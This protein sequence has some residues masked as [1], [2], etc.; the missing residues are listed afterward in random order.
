MVLFW[1]VLIAWL[2]KR[3]VHMNK[4]QFFGVFFVFLYFCHTIFTL[5]TCYFYAIF[6][7]YFRSIFYICNY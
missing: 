6:D 2:I 3:L 7:T 4:A 5:F 1:L